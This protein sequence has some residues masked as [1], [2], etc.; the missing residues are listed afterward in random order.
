[1][2]DRTKECI[3]AKTA[4]LLGACS[5]TAEKVQGEEHLQELAR[6]CETFGLEV[7]GQSLSVV[8]KIDAGHYLGKGKLQ[9]LAAQIEELQVG[10]VVFDE[11]I[12]PN[13]QKNLE[14]FF[15]RPVMDRTELII[16]V[17]AQR[18]QTKEARLQ[19]EL[20]K[21]RYQF[22]RLK[23]MW[24]HL[25]RQSSGGGGHVKGE[26]EK[27]I[28]IDRRLLR[29]RLDQLEKE[30]EEVTAQ[31]QVQRGSRQRSGIPT[32]AIVGYTNAGK[33]TLMKALTGA[34]VFI[35]DKLFATLDTTTRKLTLPNHQ[36]VLLVDTVG[37][38]RK[39]PHTLVKAFKSTLEEAIHT[40]ILLH[41][42][43]VSHPQCEEQAS[44]TLA[45]LQE[46]GAEDK[47]IITVLNKIDA[48][49]DQ[50]L[51]TR[52]Q[53]RTPRTV[54][55]SAAKQE[56]LDLLLH[57]M[58]EVL[59]SLRKVVRLRIPQKEYAVFSD[60]QRE[61]HVLEIDYEENDILVQVEIPSTEEHKILSYLIR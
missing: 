58:I 19:I 39:I 21:V 54:A 61:G 10:V 7:V 23:R 56:G 27:Q 34:D 18:A 31:R 25:S 6:L 26:G 43:D 49:Q 3:D 9:E 20:A 29:R 2:I 37:F 42:V 50:G 47:P 44:E 24:T 46:L 41:L 48:C 17:F 28:E 12:S 40:D 52:L 33:S 59:S 45:V 16:E 57:K 5:C 1:M 11:E 30:I 8:K 35:E 14:A 60:L 36:E 53:W 4:F 38:I 22:P 32:F 13:Q 55:I 51:L 15:K